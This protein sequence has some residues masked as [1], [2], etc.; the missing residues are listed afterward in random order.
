MALHEKDTYTGKPK[1]V[2]QPNPLWIKNPIRRI[3]DFYG[4]LNESDKR[5]VRQLAVKASRLSAIQC[6]AAYH[7]FK[8]RAADNIRKRDEQAKYGTVLELEGNKSEGLNWIGETP[9][10]SGSGHDRSGGGASVPGGSSEVRPIQLENQRR[11]VEHLPFSSEAAS[12]EM[13][14]RGGPGSDNKG[15]ASS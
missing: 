3:G 12:G 10:G 5:A 1:R 13:V 8:A 4:D 9:A 2:W 11:P 15:E 7:R 6:Q 14:E